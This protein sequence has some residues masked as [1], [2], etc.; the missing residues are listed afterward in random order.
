MPSRKRASGEYKDI[1]HP[2]NQE[3]REIIENKV[4]EVYNATE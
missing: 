2:I 3:T 4:L 1:A